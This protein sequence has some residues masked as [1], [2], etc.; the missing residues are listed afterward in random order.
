MANSL[1]GDPSGQGIPF[2]HSVTITDNLGCTLIDFIDIVNSHAEISGTLEVLEQ[3]S[4]FSACDGIAQL[5]SFGGVL[6][7]TYFWDNGQTYIG[8]GPDTAYNLCFGGHNIIIEDALGCRK[9]IP[10]NITQPDE[11]FAQAEQVQPVQCY[12]FDDG[13]AFSSATGGTTPYLFVWDDPCN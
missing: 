4:C 10:F 12:G 2:T 11:L 1:W 3:V 13:I 8:S 7:H 9:T 6:Q 5:S